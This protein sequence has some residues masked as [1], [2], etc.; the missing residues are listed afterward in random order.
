MSGIEETLSAP[1]LDPLD[2]LLWMTLSEKSEMEPALNKGI[3][4]VQETGISVVNHP[5]SKKSD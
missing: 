3:D 1:S 4:S 5:A 2:C